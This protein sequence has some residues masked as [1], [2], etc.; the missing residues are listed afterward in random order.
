MKNFL[1]GLLLF[2]SSISI[3]LVFIPKTGYCY[4]CPSVGQECVYSLDCG[5][6]CNCY[7]GGGHIYGVCGDK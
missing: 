6:G 1:V 2:V 5:I 7:K 3:A 4:N